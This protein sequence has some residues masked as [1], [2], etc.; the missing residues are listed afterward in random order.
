MKNI[1]D[2]EKNKLDMML[3]ITS[4]FHQGFLN[5]DLLFLDPT[6]SSDSVAHTLDVLVIIM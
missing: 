6:Y 3:L 1:V 2:L 4:I 5:R